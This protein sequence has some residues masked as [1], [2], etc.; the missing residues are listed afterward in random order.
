MQSASR[1]S[2]AAALDRLDTYVPSAST[3]DL[4]AVA[5]DILAVAALLGREPGLRRALVDANRAGE[6]RSAL[7]SQLFASKIGSV[8]LG[9][10]S[11]VVAGHWS[12]PNDILSATER[13]GAEAWLASAQRADNL[14][15]VEDELE[16]F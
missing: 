1:E 9:L 7:L 2:Y 14:A 16:I 10:L 11:T 4:A 3:E 12:R 5:D 15:E 6:E 13:L 8:A